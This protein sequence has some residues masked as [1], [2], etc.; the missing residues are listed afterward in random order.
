MS[1]KE[2]VTED[3]IKILH[4]VVTII[5]KQELNVLRKLKKKDTH[6]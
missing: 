1:I 2:I 3:M 6:N 5:F 4:I